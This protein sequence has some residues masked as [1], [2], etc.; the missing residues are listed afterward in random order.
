[1]SS[2]NVRRNSHLFPILS[3]A[4][5]KTAINISG[6]EKVFYLKVSMHVVL[7]SN[8]QD[9]KKNSKIPLKFADFS[10][11]VLNFHRRGVMSQIGQDL[12]RKYFFI[13]FFVQICWTWQTTKI[14]KVSSSLEEILLSYGHFPPFYSFRNDTKL[15]TLV[16]SSI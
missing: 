2:F 1:M 7:L 8:K 13:N 16:N 4:F 9:I 6:L 11:N 5:W 3:Q 10:K 12:W 14:W 15:Q